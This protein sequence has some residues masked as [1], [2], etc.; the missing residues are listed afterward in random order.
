MC[1]LFSFV[2]WNNAGENFGMQSSVVDSDIRV[3]PSNIKVLDYCASVKL[4]RCN[5]WPHVANCHI[6]I[7]QLL[8]LWRH[9]HYDVS[10]LRRS[11]PRSHYDVILIVTSFAT[12]LATP[13]VTDVTIVAHNIAQ[14]RPDSFPPY[15]PDNHHCSDDVY[16]REGDEIVEITVFV[17]TVLYL[18]ECWHRCTMQ[19]EEYSAQVEQVRGSCNMYEYVISMIV[20]SQWSQHQHRTVHV[21]KQQLH[22]RL[23]LQ[24]L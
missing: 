22:A 20:R 18:S 2:A 12:E 1:C 13:T 5:P 10:R 6:S 19:V 21:D 14:N 4:Q 11:S 8:S 16:L 9:S 7:S 15:P 23:S 24:C 17:W 3:C